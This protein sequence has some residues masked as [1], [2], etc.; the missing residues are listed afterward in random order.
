MQCSNCSKNAIFLV[1]KEDARIPLCLDCNVKY[2]QMLATQNESLERQ[3]NFL[4]DQMEASTG[5]YG[6]APRYPPRQVVN[7]GNVILNNI[8]VDHSTIGVLNTGNISTVDAAVTTLKQSDEGSAAETFVRLTEAVASN[9]DLSPETKNQILELLSLL[10]TEA[11]APKANRRSGTMLVLLEQLGK[12]M[13]SA[14]TLA[15]LWT[16]YAPAIQQLFQMA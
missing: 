10:S 9:P 2:Q 15:Q 3:I 6:I 8:K 14:S 1:G 12:L 13:K 11:T 16:Q 4:M 7:M 5:L